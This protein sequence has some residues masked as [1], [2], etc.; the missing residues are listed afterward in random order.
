MC[1]ALEKVHRALVNPSRV[2]VYRRTKPGVKTPGYSW[3]T[4][5]GLGLEHAQK[6]DTII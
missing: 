3:T 5:P 6:G 1:T 4:P 2:D